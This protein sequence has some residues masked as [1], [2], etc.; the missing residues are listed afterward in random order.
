[1]HGILGGSMQDIFIL[2][3][4]TFQIIKLTACFIIFKFSGL[5]KINNL[6]N[7]NVKDGLA[8]K[9]HKPLGFGKFVDVNNHATH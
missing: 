6:V 9:W 2:H 8:H 3:G 7:L 5:V 4:P 1:M